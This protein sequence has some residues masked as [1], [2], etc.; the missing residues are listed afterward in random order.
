MSK[1]FDCPACGRKLRSPEALEDH[2]SA[3]HAPV[4]DKGP[5]IASRVVDGILQRAMGGHHVDDEVIDL[6]PSDEEV[7]GEKK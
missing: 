1:T 5:S 7:E 2:F 4:D 3:K 6:L